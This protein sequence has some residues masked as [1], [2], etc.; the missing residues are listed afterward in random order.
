[1]AICVTAAPDP[2]G[3]TDDGSPILVI[4]KS[5]VCD[6]YLVEANDIQ[7][8]FSYAEV[9]VLFSAFVGLYAIAFVIKLVRRQIGF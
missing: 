8:Q 9:S 5:G 7:S 3:V 1:M 4:P 6:F 2:I